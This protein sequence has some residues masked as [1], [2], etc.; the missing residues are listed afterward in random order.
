MRRSWKRAAGIVLAAALVLGAGAWRFWTFAPFA[1][2]QDI[3]RIEIRSVARPDGDTVVLEEAY[4]AKVREVLAAMRL[5]RL[6]PLWVSLRDGSMPG[7]FVVVYE[8]GRA[9]AVGDD[10]PYVYL[11]GRFYYPASPDTLKQLGE[12]YWAHPDHCPPG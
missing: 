11:D 4:A 1:D 7:K 5:R 9:L 8:D 6:H 2:A 12:L 10:A 3:R